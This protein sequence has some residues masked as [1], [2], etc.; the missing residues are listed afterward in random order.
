MKTTGISTRSGAI[1]AYKLTVDNGGAPC[2][3][4]G[5]LSLSICKPRIRVAA[6]AGD[7]ILGFGARSVPELRGRLIY[8]ARVTEVVENG[9]YYR[10]RAFVDRPDCIYTHDGSGYAY[11]EGSRFHG[12]EDLEHDLGE[13]QEHARA[14]NLLSDQFIYFGR[15]RGPSLAAIADI[16]EEMP[17]D[18]IK[19]H[20][21]D[22][23]SR[24][25]GFIL[26]VFEEFPVG[27]RGKPT[28]ERVRSRC[29]RSD[30]G[31]LIP[32]VTR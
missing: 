9:H 17:R 14:R 11:R 19:N 1:F 24:L 16:Y 6:M 12:P 2:V 10:S 28:H 7:W 15:T 32:E 21:A 8:V 29:E 25:E 26:D 30:H 31:L 18:F 13:P 5:L 4:Q 3:H 27:V 20:D 22:V 23:R